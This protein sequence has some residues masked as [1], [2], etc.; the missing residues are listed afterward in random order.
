M[1]LGAAIVE[2]LPSALRR[3]DR[4]A[5]GK[6]GSLERAM[7]WVIVVVVIAA[8]APTRLP[9]PSH[10]SKSS[11]APERGDVFEMRDS[12]GDALCA[13]AAINNDVPAARQ[14]GIRLALLNL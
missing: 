4:H 9:Q 2:G 13:T 3:A 6:L 14:K 8:C 12:S 5:W 11:S 10:G 7:R 1:G